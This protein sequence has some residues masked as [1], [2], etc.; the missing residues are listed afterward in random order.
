MFKPTTAKTPEEYIAMI[1]EPRRSEIQLLHDLIQRTIPPQI[2]YIISGMIGYG[3]FHYKSKSGREGDWCIVALASQKNYISV[4]I[5][6]S[7][8]K[9]YVAEKYKDSFPKAS[10]GRSCIRFKRTE[11]IDLDILKKVLIEGVKTSEKYGG[12]L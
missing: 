2:P 9:E 3:S 12:L 6:A 10:I 4:Y 7:D 8:G 11:D 1:D 5:C